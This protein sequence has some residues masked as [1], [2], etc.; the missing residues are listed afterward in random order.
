MNSPR[1]WSLLDIMNLFDVYALAHILHKFSQ[2]DYTLI[3]MKLAGQGGHPPSDDIKKRMEKGLAEAEMLFTAVELADCLNAN[4]TA[5]RLWERQMLDISSAGEIVHRLQDD[6]IAALENRQFLRVADDR[7]SLI[8]HMRGKEMKGG[9]FEVIGLKTFQ[10]FPSAQ[11]DL[12]EAAN[13]LAAECNTAAVFHLMRAAEVGLRALATDRELEFGDKPLDQQDWG[14]IFPQLESCI[15]QLRNDALS[16]WVNPGVKDIQIRFYSE[17]VGELR[18]FN[19]AWRRHVSHA[20]VDGIYDRDYAMSIFN[21]V[22]LFMQKL[23]TKI[24]EISKTPKHW[25]TA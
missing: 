23:A 19:D 3:A 12:I 6:I 11:A 1:V 8:A 13:C 7:L 10:S 2:I 22:R 16:L 21:H 25:T 24:S 4:N 18:Q 20:R 17:V 5:K 9:V 14:T 15:K